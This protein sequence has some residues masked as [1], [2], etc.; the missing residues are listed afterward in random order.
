MI[1]NIES[2]E[3]PVIVCGT[4]TFVLKEM[5]IMKS[6]GCGRKNVSFPPVICISSSLREY[7]VPATDDQQET[8]VI[9]EIN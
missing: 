4:P 7:C 5:I 9:E 1:V 2:C 6:T 3:S 8:I